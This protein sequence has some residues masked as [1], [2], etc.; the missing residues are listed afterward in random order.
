MATGAVATY[1]APGIA[2]GG[3]ATFALASR[4]GLVTD[5]QQG[6]VFADAPALLAAVTSHLETRGFTKVADLDPTS[7]PATLPTADLAVNVS[8]LAVAG[9]EAGYW[10]AL[11]G[12][13]QPADLGLDGFAWVYPWDWVPVA[14]QPGSLLV[15]ISDLRDRV[16]GSGGALG[17]IPLAWAAVAYGV[18][19][20]D[21]DAAPVLEAVDRAFAQS[22]YLVR[23]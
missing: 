12:Y 1:R 7:P 20:G 18:S 8:A 14:F 2:F 5:A 17:Q 4:V 22:A 10:V 15:E 6:K 11:G 16:P 21:Y 3:F 13:T 23:P 19:G 9:P